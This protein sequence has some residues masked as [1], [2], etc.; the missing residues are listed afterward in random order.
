MNNIISTIIT[1]VIGA[2]TFIITLFFSNKKIK[3]LKSQNE[4]LKQNLKNEQTA[5]ASKKE[6]I[7]NIN[8]I[9]SKTNEELVNDWQNK[10]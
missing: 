1:G 10:K 9:K 6:E 2:I 5:S 7:K 3:N 4:A 8:N